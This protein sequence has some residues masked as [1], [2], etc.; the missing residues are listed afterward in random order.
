MHFRMTSYVG[1][2]L[3][4]EECVRT[5]MPYHAQ[6]GAI[7]GTNACCAVPFA[8]KKLNEST[9]DLR[10]CCGAEIAAMSNSRMNTEDTFSTIGSQSYQTARARV[11]CDMWRASVSDSCGDSWRKGYGIGTTGKPYVANESRAMRRAAVVW[12][13]F[14]ITQF[15]YA[16]LELI[17]E[18]V[19]AGHVC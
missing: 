2:Q 7:H 18:V 17:R 16:E 14:H 9:T 13:I 4:S 11:E 5:A 12:I 3:A 15:E 6:G 10:S 1:E 19:K 8:S